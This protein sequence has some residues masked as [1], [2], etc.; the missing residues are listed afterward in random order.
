LLSGQSSDYFGRKKIIVFSSVVFTIGALICAGAPNKEVLLL[1]RIF[2]GIGIGIGHFS[3]GKKISPMVLGA[4]RWCQ[5][6]LEREGFPL[7]GLTLPR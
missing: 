2:L 4:N 3:P 1:G 5:I 6:H 7:E